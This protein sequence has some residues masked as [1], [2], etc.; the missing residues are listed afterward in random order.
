MIVDA[1]KLVSKSKNS[2]FDGRRLQGKVLLTLVDGRIVHDARG[3]LSAPQ[4][5]IAT[6][7]W[8][9]PR[10]VAEQFPAGGSGLARYAAIFP[11]VE[12]TPAFIG[13]TNPKPIARWAATTPEGFRFAVKAPKLAT[14]DLRLVDAFEPI[15][16]FLSETAAL[17]EKRGPVLLQLP[18]SLVFDPAIAARFADGFRARY[19]DDAVVEPRHPSWFEPQAEALLNTHRIARVAADPAVSPQ[20]CVAGRLERVALLAAARIAEKVLV[21]LCR[22]SWAP[23]RFH[24]RGRRARLGRARQHR[25]GRG[26]SGRPDAPG[27]VW[28]PAPLASQ[29]PSLKH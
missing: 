12:S 5:R 4:V 20:S 1:D 22:R 17:G 14:H 25:L 23:G 27:P 26:G 21:A 13:R 16:R 18:P 6:A 7:G 9:I 19:E 10:A 2:P 3:W 28:R 8:A 11:G 24:Q 29:P 15:D